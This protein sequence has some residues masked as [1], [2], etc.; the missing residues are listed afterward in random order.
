VTGELKKGISCY[1]A[2]ARD[3]FCGLDARF[4]FGKEL[5]EPGLPEPI[6]W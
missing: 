4:W 3:G 5:P 1:D 2:R 6:K